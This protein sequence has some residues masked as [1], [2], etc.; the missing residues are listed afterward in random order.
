MK[1]SMT[2]W[3]GSSVIV[4][5]TLLPGAAGFGPPTKLVHAGN[6]PGF[7]MASEKSFMV[8]PLSSF[9]SVRWCSSLPSLMS[10]KVVGPDLISAGATNEKSFARTT[11][12]G[13]G[14]SAC[15]A[16]SDSAA[17]TTGMNIAG[18]S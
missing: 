8:F 18:L 9:T 10:L 4:A 16:D 5:S 7:C 15:G 17:A 2:Y 14:L 1:H 3:P 13:A 6:G 12:T 11:K